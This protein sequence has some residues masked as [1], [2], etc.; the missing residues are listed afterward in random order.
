MCSLSKY[1]KK[2][3]YVVLQTK[4]V[5]KTQTNNQVEFKGGEEEGRLYII[6][7]ITISLVYKITGFFWKLSFS[8]HNLI[9]GPTL[10]VECRH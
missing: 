9:C 1:V 8:R 7:E 6:C 4:K 2:E 10:D 5:R 3:V